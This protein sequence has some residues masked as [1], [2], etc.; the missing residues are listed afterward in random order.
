[1]KPQQYIIQATNNLL[2]DCPIYLAYEVS[3]VACTKKDRFR[4]NLFST[5]HRLDQELASNPKLGSNWHYQ[6]VK[7]LQ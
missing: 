3:K 1:M 6:I 4:G 2:P 5:K 7:D